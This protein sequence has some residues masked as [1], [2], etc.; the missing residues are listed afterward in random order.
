MK[1]VALILMLSLFAAI[2]IFA[3]DTLSSPSSTQ[4]HIEYEGEELSD[5]NIAKIKSMSQYMT[6]FYSDLG[7]RENLDVR[8][9]IFKTKTEGYEYMR[10]LYPDDETYKRSKSDEYFKTGY[11]GFYIPASKTAVILGLESGIDRGLSVIF[12]EISHHFTRML[13]NRVT[14]PVWVTEGLAEHFEN[15]RYVKKKG[16]ISEVSDSDKGKLRTMCMIG[17]LDVTDLL[18]LSHSEFRQKL[19]NEGDMFYA[20]SHAAVVVMMNQ[21]DSE[22]FLLLIDEMSKRNTDQKVSEIVSEI[23]PGGLEAYRRDLNQFIK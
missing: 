20:F 1:R 21:L 8:L 3:Q 6:D 15:M 18:D 10:T 2:D 9:V 7:L 12:H 13:F 14:P 5:K 11:D 4:L 16:W 17:E 19:R 22:T 23:Y